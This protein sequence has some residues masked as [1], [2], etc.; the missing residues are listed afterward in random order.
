MGRIVL[1]TGV[2][3]II[4]Q[5]IIES[6]RRC[7]PP[8]FV[9]GMDRLENSVGAYLCDHFIRKPD[10]DEASDGYLDFW[11]QLLISFKVDLVLPGIESDVVFLDHQREQLGSLASLAINAPDV[12]A[13]CSNKLTTYTQLGA[14]DVARIP[15]LVAT[16]NS[17]LTSLGPGPYVLKPSCGNGSRGIH[18]VDHAQDYIETLQRH[19]CGDYIVQ[20]YL[21]DPEHEFTASA[22]GLSGGAS[23]T[24]II[25]RRTLSRA[26]Y[27]NYVEVMPCAE[28]EDA[29]GVLAAFFHP[30]GPTNY[31]FRLHRGTYYLLEINPRFSSST[32]LK[33][34][35]GYNEAEMCIEYF[36]QGRPPAPPLIRKGHAWRKISDV[37]VYEGSDQ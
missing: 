4:G 1:V 8:V 14:V 5:G 26:G 30:I 15:T 3:A 35:F 32:S 2:G 11:R 18:I 13:V 28:I 6:L 21:G 22:F 29:I 16:E 9:I 34:A 7:Q 33:T 24:P 10:I 25:F 17:D 19:C 37:I 27:T 36:L 31:Q 23:L 20:P 12:L